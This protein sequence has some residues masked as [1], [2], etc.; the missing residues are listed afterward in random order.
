MMAGVDGLTALRQ[1]RSGDL[2]TPVVILTAMSGS[3]NAIAGLE[4]GA[5]DYLAKPFSLQ[6][7]ILRLNNVMKSSPPVSMPAMP[8]DVRFVDGE[9]FI[10]QKLLT[11][12]AVEKD[13]LA[14]LTSP[15]G[16]F[17]AA[18]P[19][20]AKRLREKLSAALPGIDILT[21]RGKGY[22]LIEISD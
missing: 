13:L 10:R 11:L 21:I 2:S 19:M 12:S 1:W 3:E 16:G 6:E 17:V 7:L 18:A 9:F 20:T 4:G 22:K 14:A 15:V 8:R 5:D